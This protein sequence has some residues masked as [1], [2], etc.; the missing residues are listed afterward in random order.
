[1]STSAKTKKVVH[2][3]EKEGLRENEKK[4]GKEVMATGWTAMPNIILKRQKQLGLDSLDLNILLH[5]MSYWWTAAEL[6]FPSKKTLAA[7]M[8]VDES[9]IRRRIAALESGGLLKRIERRVS[10][11][12]SKPNQYDLSGLIEAIK[13]FAIEESAAIEESRQQKAERT[14]RMRAKKP[15][16]RSVD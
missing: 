16:L 1:M 6:P 3:D 15:A 2:L 9:T 7:S 12:R 13:P 14:K 8:S 11:D 10:G 4:W 5:L